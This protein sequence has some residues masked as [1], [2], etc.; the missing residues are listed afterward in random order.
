[1][2]GEE[3][4]RKGEC[5]YLQELQFLAYWLRDLLPFSIRELSHLEFELM[6]AF[7]HGHT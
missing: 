6:E 5:R 3:F 1:M 4:F 7:R 2:T